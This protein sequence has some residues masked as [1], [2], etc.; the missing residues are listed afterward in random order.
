VNVFA[1]KMLVGDRLKYLGLVIGIAF[2][3]L[4]ITQQASIFYGYAHRIGAWIRDTGQADLWVMDEQAEYTED[5]KPL[6]DTTLQRV[7]SIDGVAWAVPL[8]KGYLRMRLADGT[9][10]QARLIGIDDATLLGGPPEMVEGTLADL[11]RDRAV[12]IDE[13][14][15]GDLRLRY[16]LPEEG[17]RAVR[18]GDRI[19]VND[20]EAIVVG[21]YR[22]SPEFFWD[23]VLYT[24]YTRALAMAPSERR[25][26]TFVL[27]KVKAG[28]DHGVVARAITAATGC[29][30]RTGPEFEAI[31]TDYVLAKTGILVNFGITIALGFVIGVLVAGQLLYNFVV[32]NLRYHAAMK[33]MG[34]TNGTLIRM[35][36]V[37]VLVAAGLGF[38]IGVG[39]AALSGVLLARGGLAFEM[40]W[41]IPLFGA[42]AILVV[43]CI[44]ALISISR[45]LRLEPAV[46]FKS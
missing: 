46:V 25:Q 20:H 13:A 14:S 23:P 38:G 41:R 36:L 4:L 8:W 44:A 17:P 21:S 15:L 26:L 37:Q 24:T 27:V 42:A 30:A 31:S 16:G 11:H 43:C 3:S 35:V 18:I 9:R 45:V 22:R 6:T 40:D 7:R 19:D 1:I 34:A 5:R 10:V 12:I 32:E 2:A 39:G 28:V 29:A 33:A